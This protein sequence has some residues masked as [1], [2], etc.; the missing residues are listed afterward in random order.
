MVSPSVGPLRL[1]IFGDFGVLRS[2]AS[3]VLALVQLILLQ[4]LCVCSRWTVPITHITRMRRAVHS[5]PQSLSILSLL[6]L[7]CLMLLKSY[8]SLLGSTTVCLCSITDPMYGIPC[9]I[10]I[11]SHSAVQLS[12]EG[13]GNENRTRERENWG[14]VKCHKR[15]DMSGLIKDC[16]PFRRRKS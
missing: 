5:A 9:P 13:E 14:F 15:G 6:F 8:L 1:L 12:V 3:P 16:A 11:Q 7:D 2:T 10:S 4:S